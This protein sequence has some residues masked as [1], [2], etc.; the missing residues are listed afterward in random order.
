[1]SP[2]LY[3][4]YTHHIIYLSLTI[5]SVYS[6]KILLQILK[7]LETGAVPIFTLIN[8]QG[9]SFGYEVLRKIYIPLSLKHATK[10]VSYEH[11]DI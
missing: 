1:M 8:Q 4:L 10:G 2:L 7:I 3:Y 9:L 5:F 6:L 11:K